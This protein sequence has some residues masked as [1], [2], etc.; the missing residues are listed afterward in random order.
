MKRMKYMFVSKT[1]FGYR[2]KF[3]IPG[4]CAVEGAHYVGYYRRNAIKAARRNF[5]YVG[6]HFVLIYV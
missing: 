6:K 3:D 1:S 4:K 2:V 5:G